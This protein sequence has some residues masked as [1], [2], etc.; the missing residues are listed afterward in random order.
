MQ[1]YLQIQFSEKNLSMNKL[2][3]ISKFKRKQQLNRQHFSYIIIR[4]GKKI[5][6][7][8]HIDIF[9]QLFEQFQQTNSQGEGE[10][11]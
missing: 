1:N 7:I 11:E 4:G 8:F 2:F 9:L 3:L 5:R 6:S 10:G